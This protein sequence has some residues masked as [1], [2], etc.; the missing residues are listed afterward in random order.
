MF[1]PAASIRR[2]AVVNVNPELH[3]FGCGATRWLAD[4]HYFHIVP[5]HTAP[6]HFFWA[7][8]TGQAGTPY[9]DATI[10]YIVIP[11][12][13]HGSTLRALRAAVT[14]WACGVCVLV[15]R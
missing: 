11:P 3:H 5:A 2:R 10:A 13:R 7:L 12:L 4:T 1:P 9:A 15:D 14:R 6:H 8:A